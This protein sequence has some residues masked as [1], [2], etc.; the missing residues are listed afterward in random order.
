MYTMQRQTFTRTI[1]RQCFETLVVNDNFSLC[2]YLTEHRY[3]SLY[4][5]PQLSLGSTS[6]STTAATSHLGGANGWG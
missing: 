5:V 1:Q 3:V 6:M 2:V 4:F